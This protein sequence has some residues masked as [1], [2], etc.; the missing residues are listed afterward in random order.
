VPRSRADRRSRCRIAGRGSERGK[1]S[2][3]KA[4][5]EQHGDRRDHADRGA[6][7]RRSGIRLLVATGDLLLGGQLRIRAPAESEVDAQ[8]DP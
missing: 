5:R 1:H 6:I 8:G 2:D 7:V 4:A 3:G